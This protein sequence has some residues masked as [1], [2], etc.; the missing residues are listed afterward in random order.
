V[1]EYLLSGR[2]ASSSIAKSDV[3][4]FPQRMKMR[5]YAR[6]WALRRVPGHVRRLAM[7]FRRVNLDTEAFAS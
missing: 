1:I 4:F 5:R 3:D 2:S 6:P 7:D